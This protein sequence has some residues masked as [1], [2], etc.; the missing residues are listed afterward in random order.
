MVSQSWDSRAGIQRSSLR[1]VKFIFTLRVVSD[2]KANF[3]YTFICV[4]LFRRNDSS[5][6]TA[7]SGNRQ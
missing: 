5:K 1:L 3:L 4:S 7:S 2:R 6:T